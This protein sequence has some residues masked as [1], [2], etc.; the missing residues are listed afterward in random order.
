M[1]YLFMFALAAEDPWHLI[2]AKTGEMTI[3]NQTIS[4][5]L[6]RLNSIEV[7]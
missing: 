7:S 2:N 4:K 5:T 1:I 3:C 6:R